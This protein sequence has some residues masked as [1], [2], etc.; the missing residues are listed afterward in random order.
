M[1]IE[2]QI[3]Q[4]DFIWFQDSDYNYIQG[5]E[6]TLESSVSYCNQKGLQD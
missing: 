2:D 1:I 4:L 5:A 3:E 6:I